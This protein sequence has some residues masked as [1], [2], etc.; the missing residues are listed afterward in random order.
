MQI[1]QKL[2]QEQLL[3][4]QIELQ[5]LEIE[6]LEQEQLKAKTATT[7]KTYNNGE[8]QQKLTY[9]TV[10]KTVHF[11]L[12]GGKNGGLES[13]SDLTRSINYSNK[14]GTETAAILSCGFTNAEWIEGMSAADP[15]ADWSKTIAFNKDEWGDA[16]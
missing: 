16:I 2:E 9:Y 6:Q 10:G 5:Q 4:E 1:E 12:W 7:L 13:I 15:A 3:L 8:Y 11:E 14:D